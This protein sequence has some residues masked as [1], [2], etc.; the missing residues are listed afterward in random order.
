MWIIGDPFLRAYY[1]G[2]L[3]FDDMSVFVHVFFFFVQIVYDKS[4][5]PERVGFAKAVQP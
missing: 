2:T 4:T 3:H 1:T 5:Y